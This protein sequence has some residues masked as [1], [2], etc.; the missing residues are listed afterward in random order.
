MQRQ[1]QDFNKYE[2]IKG[3][4]LEEAYYEVLYIHPH[5]DKLQFYNKMDN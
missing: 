1:Q 2:R 5:V 3:F 4:D